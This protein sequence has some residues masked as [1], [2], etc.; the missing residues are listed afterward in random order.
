MIRGIGMVRNWDGFLGVGWG[1][2]KG[3]NSVASSKG[4]GEADRMESV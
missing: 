1:G 2:E 3:S 4:G